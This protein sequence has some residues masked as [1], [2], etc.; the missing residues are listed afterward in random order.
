LKSQ[1]LEGVMSLTELAHR[2][3][4]FSIRH[5]ERVD[6]AP[7]KTGHG[8]AAGAD[9]AHSIAWARHVGR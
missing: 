6:L 1:L 7:T 3:S 4:S 9:A 2:L 8:T 5:P